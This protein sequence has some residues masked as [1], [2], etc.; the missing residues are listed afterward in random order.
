VSSLAGAK[1]ARIN[2]TTMA[3]DMNDGIVFVNKKMLE[4]GTFEEYVS[5]IDI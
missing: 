5:N 3:S 4:F 2:V 1:W